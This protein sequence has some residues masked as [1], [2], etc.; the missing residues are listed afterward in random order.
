MHSCVDFRS[1]SEALD[2]VTER[3]GR[4]TMLHM[5]NVIGAPRD[6]V[7]ALELVSQRNWAAREL[8]CE[9]PQLRLGFRNLGQRVM[10]FS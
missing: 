10:C 5:L 1:I 6:V 3:S 8:A 9:G 2:A 4:E 7:E